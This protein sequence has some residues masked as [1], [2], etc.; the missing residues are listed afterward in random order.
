MIRH[1]SSNLFLSCMVCLLL[2]A[3]L[4]E[5][6]WGLT[7]GGLMGYKIGKNKDI[8]VKIEK[9]LK[10]HNMSEDEIPKSFSTDSDWYD[11]L[12]LDIKTSVE[13]HVKYQLRE[14]NWFGL[15]LAVCIVSFGITGLVYGLISKQIVFVGIVV[16]VSLFINNPVF[17][18]SEFKNLIFL[19]KL[20]IIFTQFGVCFL[21]GYV[22]LYV[23]NKL[24]RVS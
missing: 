10:D 14:V 12:P 8:H 9:I 19:Q 2:V 16:F 23:R 11:K 7:V 13:E 17:R 22:G 21:S 5:V 4:N 15:T 24:A 6:L 1:L 20:I 18:P 3:V